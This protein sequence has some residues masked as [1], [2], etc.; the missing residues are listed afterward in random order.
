MLC[1]I[2]NTDPFRMALLD[3][4][5]EAQE[6]SSKGSSDGSLF[7]DE[8]FHHFKYR[9]NS[10]GHLMKDHAVRCIKMLTATQQD[11]ESFFWQ[12]TGRSNLLVFLYMC[13]GENTQA[14][15]Q[16]ILTRN[17]VS[18][19]IN[20][21]FANI[22][23]HGADY[24]ESEVQ[25]ARDQLSNMDHHERKV[26]QLV[27]AGE[28]AYVCLKLGPAFHAESIDRYEQLLSLQR[29]ET[30]DDE[31]LQRGRCRWRFYLAQTY[32]RQLNKGQIQHLFARFSIT[33]IEA[34]F[35]K[36]SKLLLEVISTGDVYYKGKAMIDLADVYK[37][38]QAADTV[39]LKFP[40]ERSIAEYVEDAMLA[41]PSDCYVLERC[42]RHFRQH[43]SGENDLLRSIDVLEKSLQLCPG[44]HVAL[45]HMGLA[46]REM[47][48]IQDKQKPAELVT[49][50]IRK[51]GRNEQ[52]PYTLRQKELY[53]DETHTHASDSNDNSAS[54]VAVIPTP[55]S[56]CPSMG[57]VSVKSHNLSVDNESAAQEQKHEQRKQT[58][59]SPANYRTLKSRFPTTPG[60]CPMQTE[61]PSYF[62]TLRASNPEINSQ[63][64]DMLQ[65]AKECFEKA[66]S[67]TEH[68]SVR[69]LVDL[70]RACI[71]LGQHDEAEDRFR[72][73]DKLTDTMDDNDACYL[74]EQWAI[75]RNKPESV[76]R[77]YI[78]AETDY[79][80]A[81]VAPLYRK[82]IFA[83]I[84]AQCRSRTAFYHLRDIL[85]KQMEQEPANEALK[86]EYDVLYN[87]TKDFRGKR[88]KSFQE[89]LDR[90]P[91]MQKTAW[92]MID[93]LYH[94]RH[95][96]DAPTAFTYLAA[97]LQ[98]ESSL[99]T[100]QQTAN[101]NISERRLQVV[102]LAW[103]TACNNRE[104]YAENGKV[105]A[106]VFRWLV[107]SKNLSDLGIQ[108]EN[109]SR[110]TCDRNPDVC[111]LATDD[112]VTADR[113]TRVLMNT[114]GLDTIRAFADG[115]G[116]MVGGFLGSCIFDY[117]L[118]AVA[119]SKTV[120]IVENSSNSNWR[121]LKPVLRELLTIDGSRVCLVIDPETDCS[122]TEERYLKHWPA[123]TLN[124]ECN[125]LC[126][127]YAM[128]KTMF[129][130][131]KQNDLDREMNYLAVKC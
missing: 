130:N 43:S 37:K 67:L 16:N 101:R 34:L 109:S 125:D 127:A 87:T 63:G 131:R 77:N 115:G 57:R 26:Q 70:A 65:K 83:S 102:E 129:L 14:R 15:M 82:S 18:N 45:H 4:Q 49:N 81:N 66:N 95:A 118:V 23:I 104:A 58:G 86:L 106:D 72:Q 42:G 29:S 94:R 19:N 124:N 25:K 98:S 39:V 61:N 78:V 112:S 90:N 54:S 46:Y 75:M 32:N 48:M 120:V 97:L 20:A 89:A 52:C 53:S 105:F 56:A 79:T 40:V 62:D 31:I 13:I 88:V 60:K 27:C 74:Y 121:R 128:F 7:E 33:N 36:I 50:R 64:R 119:I 91:A 38:C 47:W 5:T 111:I 117:L 9:L 59:T 12:E 93:L 126:V 73:A 84:R 69:Y 113:I 99:V 108:P 103:R 51:I 114:C 110:R 122:N 22:R 76:Q 116:D 11:D 41:A 92:N 8:M 44:R 107:G 55:D 17:K 123:F 85:R 21:L 1:C 80:I 100:E 10:R 28:I 35:D 3:T 24:N 6:V 68:T 2:G 30:I 71:S 96:H